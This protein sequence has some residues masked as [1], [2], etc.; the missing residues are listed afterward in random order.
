ML[1]LRHSISIYRAKSL[2]CLAMQRNLYSVKCK[3]FILFC[4][5]WFQ[6]DSK[7][8]LKFALCSTWW[9]IGD[10]QVGDSSGV[11]CISTE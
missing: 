4:L 11:N 9:V 1:E 5:V 10:N 3:S 7:T 6:D 8:K 2:M